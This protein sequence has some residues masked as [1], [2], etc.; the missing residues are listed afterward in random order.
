[1][2]TI[3]ITNQEQ[4]DKIKEVKVGEKLI[5]ECELSLKSSLNVYGKA[6]FKKSVISSGQA[7]VRA[8]DQATVSAS[9]QA[10]VSASGQATVR[11]FSEIKSLVLFGFSVLFKPFDLKIKI[12]KSKTV[13]VQNVKPLG[14]FENN[15]I[16]KTKTIIVYKKVS[17]DFLTQEGTQNETKWEIGSTVTHPNW[18]PNKEEC[19]AGKFHACS[20]PYFCDEF[21]N[22][23][24]DRYIAISVK[25]TDLYEWTKNSQF[26]HKIGFREA[27]VL[28][29]CDSFGRP[30]EAN[31]DNK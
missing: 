5:C 13:H 29:E 9:G 11:I 20:R 15:G 2:K 27:K 22:E 8:W 14:W 1:M 16:T 24:G 25:L 3:I 17:K 26:P 10:T 28:N 12:K 18:E 4:F 31:H 30:L 23:K 7:T 6:W 21:R 19:G